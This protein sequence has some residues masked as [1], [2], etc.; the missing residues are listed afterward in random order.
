MERTNP[1]SMSHAS[2]DIMQ[3][4]PKNDVLANVELS[5][6]SPNQKGLEDPKTNSGYKTLVYC[7]AQANWRRPVLSEITR[8]M[9]LFLKTIDLYH[10][11]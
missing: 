4:F 10:V 1:R 3:D 7:S 8:E 6:Y 11:V 2:S 5:R 9:M